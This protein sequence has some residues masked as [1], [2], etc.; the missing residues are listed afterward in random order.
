MSKVFNDIFLNPVKSIFF[1]KEKYGEKVVIVRF[2]GGIASQIYFYSMVKYFEN[3]G[4]KV[5]VDLSWFDECGMDVDNKF[6]RNFDLLKAFNIDNLELA[7]KEEIEYY[8]N[9]FPLKSKIYQLAKPPVYVGRY[10]DY[11]KLL[12]KYRKDFIKIFNPELDENNRL[13]L[14]KIQSQNSCAIHVRRGDLSNCKFSYYGKTATAQ[15]FIN[16]INFIK[17]KVPD[18][19]FF[20][21]S[22]EVDWIKEEIVPKLHDI[23]YEIVDANGSD[24]GYL[25]L[26]LIAQCNHFI[27]SIGS[28]AKFGAL[29]SKNLENSYFVVSND[30]KNLI[31]MKALCYAKIIKIKN[32]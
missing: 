21:F 28:L 19:K 5:K 2:D 32:S 24:K 20:F 31:C 15:Y 9:K 29:L 12:K 25:D 16:A 6:Q 23:N 22:D 10:Y 1:D 4:Y 30:D 13:W 3:K 7:T 18:I 26:Y 11:T 14:S 8:K 27:S 17:D